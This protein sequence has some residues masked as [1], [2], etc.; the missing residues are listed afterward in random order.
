MPSRR[1]G[2]VLV[3]AEGTV[4]VRVAALDRIVHR[5]ANEQ[6]SRTP[7]PRADHHVTGGVPMCWL[8]GERVIETV[9]VIDEMRQPSLHNRQH[10]VSDHSA[11]HGRRA[12]AG[13]V[14]ELAPA[15]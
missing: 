12:F 14:L 4:H 7:A 9:P 10:T 6:A 15:K 2:G 3:L 11:A 13:P 5:I 8:D 1:P